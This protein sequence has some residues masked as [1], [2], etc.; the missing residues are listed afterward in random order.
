MN[1]SK[2]HQLLEELKFQGMLGVI[3]QVL[4]DAEKQVTSKL[5]SST[6]C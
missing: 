5:G 6:T 3:D 4:A 1:I 2:T